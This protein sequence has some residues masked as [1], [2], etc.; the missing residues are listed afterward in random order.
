MKIATIESLHAD[1]GQRNFD[2]LKITTDDGHRR[3][4]R[5]QRVVR[6]PRRVGGHRR[7]R[8]HDRGQGPARLRGAGDAHV[9]RAPPGGG[10]RHPAGDRR[11]RE[12]AA[13][14]QGQGARRSRLRAARRPRARPHPP[15]LVALRD[16]SARVGARRCSSRRCAPS[17]TSSRPAGRSSAKGYTA[18]KTNVFILGKRALPALA[19]ASRAGARASPS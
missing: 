7:A 6:R 8:A 18:L 17:T 2:F 3:L 16:L 15:L 12:R 5:V 19:R 13:R 14:H 11:H 1:A 4:E 10:R 9:R